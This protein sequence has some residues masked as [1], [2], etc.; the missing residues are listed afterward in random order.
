[1]IELQTTGEPMTTLSHTCGDTAQDLDDVTNLVRQTTR[2]LDSYPVKTNLVG[3]LITVETY[4]I[5][6]AWGTD[7]TQVGL[8]H[9]LAPGQSIKLTNHKQ[10]IDF[11]FINK[12]N[13]ENAVLMITPE[14]S[15]L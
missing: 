10:I 9:V 7:P 6:I 4:S 1:M 14:M 8:G 3:C 15:L 5:R 11:R 12:T 2:T 13:G